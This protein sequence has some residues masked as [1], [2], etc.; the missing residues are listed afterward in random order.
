MEANEA[1]NRYGFDTISAG[2]TIAWAMECNENGLFTEEEL[3]GLDLS[4]GNGKVFRNLLE[5]M[6]NREGFMGEL[7]ADGI[8]AAAEK[9]GRGSE[10]FRTD[11]GGIDL[12]MH[13][14][15]CWPGFGLSYS[16][17]AGP[18]RHTLG[19]LGFFEHAFADKELFDTYP[20]LYKLRETMHDYDKDKGTPQRLVSSWTHFCNCMG[21]CVLAKM[22]GYANYKA[23]VAANASTGWD[24]DLEEAL[25]I[26]ERIQT[27]RHMFNLREGLRPHIEFRLQP[28][29]YGDPP[30]PAGPTAGVTVPVDKYFDDYWK[31]MGIDPAT[32]IPS[33]KRLDELGIT[34]FIKKYLV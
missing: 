9:L 20:D 30:L 13:D 28:R 31:A 16:T 32:C 15:R 10:A 29:N 23:I 12:P 5:R 14:P 22:G 6:A 17:D 1:C 11:V 4:W 2:S 18:G 33:D 34:D 19:G 26:G 27:V 21:L 24:I 8:K 7:L 25:K 3:D